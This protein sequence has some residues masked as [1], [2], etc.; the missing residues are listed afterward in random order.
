M[1]RTFSIR[2]MVGYIVVVQ[3]AG[4][5]VKMVHNGVE[6]GII[7]TTLKTYYPKQAVF[8]VSYIKEGDA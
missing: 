3:E 8:W 2:S 1:S 6:Y 4:H 5:F 7:K